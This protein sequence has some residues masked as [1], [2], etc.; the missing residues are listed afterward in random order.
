MEGHN[1]RFKRIQYLKQLEEFI[2][3]GSKSG[4]YHADMNWTNFEK[5]TTDH[6][7]PNLPP[8]SVLVIDNASY[9]NTKE[10][11]DPT[12]ATRKGDMICCLKDTDI[13]TSR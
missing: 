3:E 11:R 9:H 12:M 10:L 7:I 5:W 13:H 4:D 2:A 1:I 6:L 8:R